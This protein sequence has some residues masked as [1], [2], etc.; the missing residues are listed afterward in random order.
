MKG[1][2]STKKGLCV[3]FANSMSSWGESLGQEVPK[4]R[5]IALE[6]EVQ[7]CTRSLLR[8]FHL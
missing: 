7:L 6:F 2:Q 3:C 4:L 8:H 1:T 5:L